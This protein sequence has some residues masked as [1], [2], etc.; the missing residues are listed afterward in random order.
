MSVPQATV[1][2]LS[3]PRSKRKRLAILEAATAAFLESGYGAATMDEIATRAKVSKQTI[4]HHF[5][6][7]DVLFAAIVE[8]RCDA[9]LA[10]I[11]TVE[12][13]AGDLAETLRL[14]GR[15]FLTRVLS[16]ASLSLHR[17]LV[18][19][20]AR[21][22]ELGRLS[23]EC[24]PARL[25]AGLAKLLA[26]HGPRHGLAIP[27]PDRSAEQFFGSLLGFVQLQAI[28]C[29]NADECAAG[30]DSNVERTV[31]VFIAGHMRPGV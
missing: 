27:D 31:S 2:A 16:P 23:Y 3:Q 6:S 20:S 17:L 24:G 29:D 7:K 22:P 28:L 10:P 9:F 1:P 11:A 13:T 15:D 4:Y 8:Q 19:E 14:L 25:V 12:L 30:I 26:V 18:S 5:G 21:F